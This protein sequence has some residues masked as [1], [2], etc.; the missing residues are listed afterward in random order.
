MRGR[1]DYEVPVQVARVV[2]QNRERNNQMQNNQRGSPNV[3]ALY[4][5]AERLLATCSLQDKLNIIMDFLRERLAWDRGCLG[6][7]EKEQGVLRVKACFGKNVYPEYALHGIAADPALKNPALTAIFGKKTVVVKDPLNDPRCEDCKDTLAA[8][9]TTCFLIVPLILGDDVIG[10][11]GVDRIGECFDFTND[12]VELLTAFA[13]LAALAIENAR[14]YDEAKELSLTDE[15][16]GLRNIRYFREQ[17]RREIARASRAQQPLSVA[18]L[19][20]DNLK[21]VNDSFGHRA[22][23]ALLVKIGYRLQSCLRSSDVI[24]RYGG[25]EFVLLFHGVDSETAFICAKRCLESVRQMPF[26]DHGIKVTVSIGV[27][28]FPAE[29]SGEEELLH[30]ADTL[31]Y[32]AKK[33]G[34]N[35]IW[36]AKPS[37]S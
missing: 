10:V 11:I 3:Q 24:A 29:A 27:A 7:M 5:A 19:D 22:G 34:G 26:L 25:D 17:L 12:D 18:L 35:Q 15:L 1:A 20:V 23:D 28:S 6:L 31:C 21:V 37:C 32:K 4:H 30:Q 33:A 9:G 16:T 8:L 36:I 14:L 2:S 13:N